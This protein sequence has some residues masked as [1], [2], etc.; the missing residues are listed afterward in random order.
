MIQIASETLIPIS[1]VAQYLSSQGVTVDRSSVY[2]WTK[3]VGKAGVTLETV[4]VGGV[5]Y[6]SAQAIQRFVEETTRMEENDV[7]V[8]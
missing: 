2:R 4:V 8:Q 6:T 7:H 3:G 1:K 5:K